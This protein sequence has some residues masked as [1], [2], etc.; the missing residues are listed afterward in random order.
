VNLK[1]ATGMGIRR[2]IS[3]CFPIEHLTIS[4]RNGQVGTCKNELATRRTSELLTWQFQRKL[5]GLDGV[6]SVMMLG[7]MTRGGLLA[8][9]GLLDARVVLLERVRPEPFVRL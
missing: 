8:D 6:G 3:A 1:P 2:Q 9:R 4:P 7:G 5:V